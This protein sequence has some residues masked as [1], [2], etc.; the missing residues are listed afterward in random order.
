MSPRG[1]AG[2]PDQSSPKLL[3]SCYGHMPVIVPNFIVLNQTMYE[4][5]VTKFFFTHLWILVDPF[6]TKFTN[7]GINVQQGR[8]I[9]V[10]RY[11]N[12]CTRYLLPNFV[13]FVDSVANKQTKK[14]SKQ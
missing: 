7:L 9:T 8:S 6:G 14:N 4:K 5:R 11:D 3:K 10:S 12:L 2:P 13:D 1:I